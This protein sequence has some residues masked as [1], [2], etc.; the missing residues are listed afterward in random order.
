MPLRP[1]R[2]GEEECGDGGKRGVNN[3]GGCR[4]LARAL[5]AAAA[6]ALFAMNLRA[7]VLLYFSHAATSPASPIAL[8]SLWALC[9]L[10]ASSF[11]FAAVL[12]DGAFIPFISRHVLYD[13]CLLLAVRDRVR[14]LTG[15]CRHDY[16]LFRSELRP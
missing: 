4:S 12:L 14:A 10:I 2:R 3:P 11:F 8:I 1:T 6:A 9:T 7:R 5:V 13:Q 16:D 15:N